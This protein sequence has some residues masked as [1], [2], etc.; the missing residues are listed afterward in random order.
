VVG[1]VIQRNIIA[2]CS[3]G[4]SQP[5]T[6]QMV[7]IGKRLLRIDH[8]MLYY[9]LSCSNCNQRPDYFILRCHAHIPMDHLPALL[10]LRWRTC[11]NPKLSYVTAIA[12]HTNLIFFTVLVLALPE[13]LWNGDLGYRLAGV[14]SFHLL[15]ILLGRSLST[16]RQYF[17]YLARINGKTSQFSTK[18]FS[19]QQ[20]FNRIIAQIRDFLIH[21]KMTEMTESLI[22]IANHLFHTIT[23]LMKFKQTLPHLTPA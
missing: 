23:L 4:G 10:R 21:E 19:I 3:T 5:A 9:T 15:L 12:C 7:W 8:R 11:P 14:A 18:C 17:M 20:N 22:F 16:N 1:F 2:C 13:T 6:S